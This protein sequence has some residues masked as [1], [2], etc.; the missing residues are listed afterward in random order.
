MAEKDQLCREVAEGRAFVSFREGAIGFAPTFKYD[1]NSSSYDSSKKQRTPAYCDRVLFRNRRAPRPRQGLHL[2]AYGRGENRESDHRPVHAR[3]ELFARARVPPAQNLAALARQVEALCLAPAGPRR[4]PVPPGGGAAAAIGATGGSSATPNLFDENGSSGRPPAPAQPLPPL[5][6]QHP[7][8]ASAAPAGEG[9]LLDLLDA[10]VAAPLPPQPGAAS[11]PGAQFPS[12]L[13]SLDGRSAF[14]SR[15][16]ASTAAAPGLGLLL[17]ASS[18]GA[19]PFT[20]LSN[21]SEAVD[22]WGTAPA[23]FVPEA[24]Q[25]G[26]EPAGW[27]AF[28]GGDSDGE[29]AGS[30]GGGAPAAAPLT[31]GVAA[32]GYVDPFA[33]LL[34]GGAG[35]AGGA[36]AEGGAL[37]PAGTHSQGL[38]WLQLG[39]AGEPRAE[40]ERGGGRGRDRERSRRGGARGRH[41]GQP[42]S[43]RRI[44]RRGL[45][46]GSRG[47][48]QPVCGRRAERGG[49]RRGGWGE[50][51][52]GAARGVGGGVVRGARRVV[53]LAPRDRGGALGAPRVRRQPCR[54]ARAR[55]LE[56]LS[57]AAH[58]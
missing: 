12:L 55:S 27:V 25:A 23:A 51:G 45:G 39:T 24:A 57:R 13:D 50:C 37:V 15:L 18:A 47:R 11:G 26:G 20:A 44:C 40:I 8:G 46:R 7:L 56:P 6:A 32:P 30:K 43:S 5:P 54:S 17:P 48:W 10:P 31:G 41:L 58:R 21:G 33:E 53:L 49:G 16:S 28:G 29:E 2:V 36:G 3:F 42:R 22:M 1:L 4:A 38:G 34:A 19:D 52:G 9:D 35:G 14:T